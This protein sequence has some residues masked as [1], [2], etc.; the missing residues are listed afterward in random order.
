MRGVR[1]KVVSIR[2][3]RCGA[4]NEVDLRKGELVCSKCGASLLG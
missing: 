2:C 3:P 1:K 4:Y